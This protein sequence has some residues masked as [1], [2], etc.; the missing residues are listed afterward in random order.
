MISVSF[1]PF[2]ELTTERLLLRA[3]TSD[4]SS[5]VFRLRSEDATLKY[6]ERAPLSSIEEA[7]TLVNRMIQDRAMNDGITWALVLKNAPN[8]MIGSIGFWRLI[9]E[10]YRAEIGYMLLPEY[11]RNGY[12]KE[13]LKAVIDYGFKEMKLHSIEANVNPNNEAS[14]TLLKSQGFI[15]EAHFKENYYF[16]GQFLDSYIYSLIKPTAFD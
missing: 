1:T 9:K 10:H 3:I 13:A 11:W 14:I 8:T 16:N 4:D 15:K 6:I 12:M 5:Q 2:P 7:N